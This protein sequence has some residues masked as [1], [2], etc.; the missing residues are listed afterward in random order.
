MHGA[1]IRVVRGNYKP[2]Q[3]LAQEFLAEH[4]LE[5]FPQARRAVF[6]GDD[7]AY[8]PRTAAQRVTTV[9]YKAAVPPRHRAVISVEREDV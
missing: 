4:S 5:S 7:L 3:A 9:C 1:S 8:S 2:R 6:L